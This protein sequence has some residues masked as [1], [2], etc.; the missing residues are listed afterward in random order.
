MVILNIF[1]VFLLIAIT[2]YFV[3]IEFAIV[4]V[5]RSRID[6][7]VA[8]GNK[9][10]EA[11]K[12]VITNLDEYLSACQ[13]G[14]TVTA[15][16]LGWLGE[17][18]VQV[19][20]HPVFE[21][22]GLHE[23][24]TAI[25]SFVLSFLIITYFNVVIGELAPKTI[26]IQKAEAITLGFTPSLILFHKISLPFIKI[27]NG[28][29]R[30]IVKMT[31]L[32][33]TNE[34]DMAHSEEELRIILSESYEKGEINQS[35][36]RYVNKIFEFDNRLAREIMVPRTEMVT[37][38]LENSLEENLS[39]MKNERYTRYPVQ[40]GEKDNIIGVINVKELFQALYESRELEGVKD[41]TQLMRPVI[42]VIETVYIHDLLIRMQKER[43]HIAILVDE[44]GGTAGLVTV[45]DILEEIVGEIQDEFDADELPYIQKL[46]ENRYV[47]DGKALIEEINDVLG[48]FIESDD[49]D[50][51]GG[52]IL[53][54]NL[55]IQ[56]GESVM[57]DDYQFKIMEIENHH[58]ISVEISKLPKTEQDANNIE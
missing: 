39:I 7:L 34:S 31:G 54:Q 53:S 29:A 24:L 22:I 13:L 47:V 27:L 25:L 57:E 4:Q 12:R 49:M 14:I 36:Y 26:S 58:I 45:E 48:T 50:T 52:W 40:D 10:A 15:L 51:I 17:P 2:A 3:S 8:E 18:T 35:E 43:I 9:K 11:A 42:M 28:S 44:Y 1:L 21:K 16:G 55:D 37:V 20:L 46:G 30:L 56:Q 5:R 32:E 19:L 6:Q 33:P 41:L 23:S 38:A